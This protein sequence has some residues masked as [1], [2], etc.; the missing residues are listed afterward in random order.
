MAFASDHD[1]MVGELS[2]Y[3]F[4]VVIQQTSPSEVLQYTLHT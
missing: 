2:F 4:Y 1:N 3:L